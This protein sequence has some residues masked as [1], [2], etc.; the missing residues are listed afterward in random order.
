[1]L[2]GK[3]ISLSL[4]AFLILLCLLPSCASVRPDDVQEYR[5]FPEYGGYLPLVPDGNRLT[6]RSDWVLPV[7]DSDGIESMALPSSPEEAE[8]RVRIRARTERNTNIAMA[9]AWLLVPFSLI[10]NAVEYSLSREDREEKKE[11]FHK[12]AGVK[13]DL[14]IVDTRGTE[15][16]DASVYEPSSLYAFYT[17][18]DHAGLRAFGPPARDYY[19]PGQKLLAL[20]ATYLPIY[21]GRSIE[22][23]K[24]ETRL[25]GRTDYS[26]HRAERGTGHIVY[27]SDAFWLF[28]RYKDGSVWQWATAPRDMTLHVIAWAPGYDPK[29]YSVSGVKPKSTVTGEISLQPLPNNRKIRRAAK[30][31][32]AIIDILALGEEK[33]VFNGLSLNKPLYINKWF[34]PPGEFEAAKEQLF[35]WSED[36]GL[37]PYFRW[38][39]YELVRSVRWVTYDEE[40]EAFLERNEE[41]AKTYSRTVRE[42]PSNPWIFSEDLRQWESNLCPGKGSSAESDRFTP[43]AKVISEARSLLKRGEAIDHRD[44]RL[45]ILRAAIALADGDRARALPLLRYVDHHYFF[46]LY[47]HCKFSYYN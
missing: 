21:L 12:F 27:T 6:V 28:A 29:H 31:F 11:R 42:G 24:G 20:K 16:P 46:E 32:D 33:S 14:R 30:R 17:Y 39:V 25:L 36:A 47:Y 1:M 15:I 9:P 5:N 43:S 18:A 40:I 13:V 4:S 38:N 10:Y 37:P 44:P 23:K 45:Q 3:R 34:F 7:K 22:W 26:F 8:R 41:R 2:K 35:A 19:V